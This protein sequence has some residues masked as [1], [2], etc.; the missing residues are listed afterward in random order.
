MLIGRPHSTVHQVLRRGGCSRPKPSERAAV[1]RYEW[2]CPGTT[3][4][5]PKHGRKEPDG[6]LSL[7]EE[8]CCF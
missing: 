2:P 7:G 1:V 8:A 4:S 6:L 3:S 5:T